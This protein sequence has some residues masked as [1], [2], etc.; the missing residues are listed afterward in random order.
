MV[1]KK[2]PEK[3]RTTIKLPNNISKVD[4]SNPI[5]AADIIKCAH[6]RRR[7]IKKG[8]RINSHFDISVI[9]L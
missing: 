8:I 1:V 2:I 4:C 6:N 9:P 3:E 5:I 7:I